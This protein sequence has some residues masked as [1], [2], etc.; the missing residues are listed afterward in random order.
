MS[1]RNSPRAR[2]KGDKLEV[3]FGQNGVGLVTFVRLDQPKFL[4]IAGKRGLGDA[5]LLRGEAPA[6]IFLVRN[7]G[8][9]D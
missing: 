5:Q 4:Q 1:E 9:G 2:V 8:V 7:P 6:E 3:I